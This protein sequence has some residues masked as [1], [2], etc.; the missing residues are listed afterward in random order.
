LPHGDEPKCVGYAVR[1]FKISLNDAEWSSNEARADGMRKIAIAQLGSDTIDQIVFSEKMAMGA[2]TRL[3]PD[4]LRRIGMNEY[5]DKCAAAKNLSEAKAADA[6]YAARAAAYAAYAAYAARAAAADA[7]YAESPDYY[8]RLSAEI[9]LDVLIEMK[10]P[11]C[12]FLFLCDVK[13]D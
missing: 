4:Y 10:S 9:C 3:L 11:G 1:R 5:A 2:V 13:K 12:E 6:A 8:L 7:A